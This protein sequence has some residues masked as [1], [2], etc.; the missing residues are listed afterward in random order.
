MPSSALNATKPVTIQAS[1]WK[2]AG[3]I[4]GTKRLQIPSPIRTTAN[5]RP[6]AVLRIIV[7]NISPLQSWKNGCCAKPLKSILAR[8]PRPGE[9]LRD[10]REITLPTD[11][12]LYEAGLAHCSS[13]EPMR[14][15]AMRIRLEQER[16]QARRAELEAELLE[17]ELD[18]RRAAGNI[19][20][21]IGA[22]PIAA[23]PAPESGEE[24]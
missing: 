13:C 21:E 2:P 5:I 22:W 24:H 16:L 11:G 3:V 4:A 10:K 19:A 6:W 18:R 7:G 20:L 23:L 9:E 15:E 1:V 12:T 17:L 8:L 14:E